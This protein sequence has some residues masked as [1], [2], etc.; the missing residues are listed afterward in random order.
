MPTKAELA[1]VCM[2]E[3]PGSVILTL[4]E[5]IEQWSDLSLNPYCKGRCDDEL[6]ESKHTSNEEKNRIIENYQLKLKT[7]VLDRLVRILEVETTVVFYNYGEHKGC[8]YGLEGYEYVSF[9]F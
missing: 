1:K 9:N 4:P 6:K 5:A 3:F 7:R 8:R 2:E